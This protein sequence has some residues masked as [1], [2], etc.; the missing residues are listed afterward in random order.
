MNDDTRFICELQ[1]QR[2]AALK[3]R[4][5]LRAELGERVGV[6]DDFITACGFNV[7]DGFDINSRK[8]SALRAELEQSKRREAALMKAIAYHRQ[9]SESWLGLGSDSETL[10]RIQNSARDVM[11][12]DS[13]RDY[14][15]REQ[16][17]PLASHI[18]NN[19]IGLAKQCLDELGL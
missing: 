10:R 15:S 9:L 17:R 14:L 11:S 8:I 2:D 6:I 7:N 19:C 13:G 18:R 3:E 12:E 5:Q 1:D 4:D 16:V